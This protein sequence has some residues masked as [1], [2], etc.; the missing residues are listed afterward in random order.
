MVQKKI[1]RPTANPKHN[2]TRIRMTDEQVKKLAYC[3]RITG[4]TK[5]E[6]IAMGIEKVYQEI[7]EKRVTT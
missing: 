3:A 5:T 1:G 2:N 4:K 6:I 7:K